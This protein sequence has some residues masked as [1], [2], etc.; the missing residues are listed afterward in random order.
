MKLSKL[1]A[2]VKQRRETWSAHQIAT[3]FDLPDHAARL[4]ALSLVR[5]GVLSVET[6]RMGRRKVIG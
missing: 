4:A 1:T 6:D 5:Q 2:I 3:Q